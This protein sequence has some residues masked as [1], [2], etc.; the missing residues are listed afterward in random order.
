MTRSEARGILRKRHGEM[1]G[2][3]KKLRVSQQ[4]VADVIDGV[5]PVRAGKKSE[6]ILAAAIDRAAEIEAE[7]ITEPERACA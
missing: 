4:F 5:R 2:L 1:A 7:K 6:R 3:A